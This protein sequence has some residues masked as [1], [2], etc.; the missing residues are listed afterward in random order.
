[1]NFKASTFPERK[2]YEKVWSAK[3]DYTKLYLEIK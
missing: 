3:K 2:K 1:M